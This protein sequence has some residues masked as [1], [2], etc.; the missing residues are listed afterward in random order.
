M[1][2]SK[3]KGNRGER[4]W[5]DQL[6]T[7]GFVA[8]RGQQF[9]G[10]V[11]SPDVCCPSLPTVHWEVKR[12]ERPNVFTFLRQ[13]EQDAGTEKIPVVALRRNATPWICIVRAT[14]FLSL[15]KAAGLEAL[16][17]AVAS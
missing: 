4:E 6:R 3:Q 2:R 10:G 5:R 15:L 9:S 11:Q 13:A 8:W 1:I 7:A 17:P 14:D 16:K 12:V